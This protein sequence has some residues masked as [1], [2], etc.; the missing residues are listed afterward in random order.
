[1][2]MAPTLSGDEIR[3]CR[4]GDRSLFGEKIAGNGGHA[5]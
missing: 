1:M 5:R 2:R 4:E 3:Q